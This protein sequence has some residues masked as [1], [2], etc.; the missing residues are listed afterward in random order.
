MGRE[1][2]HRTEHSGEPTTI[3]TDYLHPGASG[4]A[5]LRGQRGPEVYRGAWCLDAV[6]DVP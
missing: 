1:L 6:G 3:W 5:A 2:H 4:L